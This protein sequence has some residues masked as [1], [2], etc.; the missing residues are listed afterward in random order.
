[1]KNLL[2]TFDEKPDVSWWNRIMKSEQRRV[3]SGGEYETY[4][5]GWALHFFGIYGKV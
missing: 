1:M 5:E 4:F 2:A 3:G